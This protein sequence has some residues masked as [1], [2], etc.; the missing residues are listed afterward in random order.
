MKIISYDSGRVTWL[1]PTEEFLPLGSGDGRAIIEQVTAKYEFSH[2]P[3]NPTREEVD[4]NGL[5][6]GSGRFA[7]EG[8]SF[9]INEFIAYND[10]IVAVSAA[11]EPAM[12]FL[13]DL[14]Q[15]LKDA[16]SF[17]APITPIKK[18]NV[19]NIIVEFDDSI[20]S[21]LAEH[22]LIS[23]VIS[24]NLNSNEGTTF[25]AR[26]SRVDFTLD[27]GPNEKPGSLPKWTLEARANVP[28][29]QN[30]Y[31]SSAAVSTRQHLK[32]I[33]EVEQIAVKRIYRR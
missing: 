9:H 19:S 16:F 1:F 20:N 29:S 30:R 17:R 4:K 12:A 33:E 32:M 6:F 5:R 25:P 27:K 23:H 11:T 13:E 18:I 2:P 28:I 22:E 15:F 3:K 21:M 8:T 7:F 24:G 31:F 14:V 26:L 10:G